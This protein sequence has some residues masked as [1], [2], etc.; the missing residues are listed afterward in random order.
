MVTTNGHE[1]TR[2]FEAVFA[3]TDYADL[4][5]LLRLRWFLL[6]CENLCNGVDFAHHGVCGENAAGKHEAAV[7]DHGY[8]YSCSFVWIETRS[9]PALTRCYP[10]SFTFYLGNPFPRFVVN[11]LRRASNKGTLRAFRY[12]DRFPTLKIFRRPGAL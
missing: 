11:E 9:A 4:W 2:I 7:S 12:A 5:A 1:L 10:R 3:S 8:N 6:I